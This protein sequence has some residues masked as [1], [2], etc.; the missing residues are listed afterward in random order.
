[1]SRS[2]IQMIIAPVLHACWH[3]QSVLSCCHSS[4][5]KSNCQKSK[6]SDKN[7]KGIDGQSKE[8]DPDDPSLCSENE[9]IPIEN[10]PVQVTRLIKPVM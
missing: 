2:F 7:G 6:E 3:R 9:E 5:V 1:L 8:R 4:P 10:K